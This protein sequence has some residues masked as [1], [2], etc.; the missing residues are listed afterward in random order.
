[1]FKMEM[2]LLL[3]QVWIRAK[4]HLCNTTKSQFFKGKMNSHAAYLNQL[5]SSALEMLMRSKCFT[6]GVSTLQLISAILLEKAT[7]RLA[8]NLVY[9]EPIVATLSSS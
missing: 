7:T 8:I 5:F 4:P 2:I 9:C 3:N 6:K 1:M